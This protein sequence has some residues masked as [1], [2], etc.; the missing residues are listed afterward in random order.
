M[1]MLLWLT[2]TAASGTVRARPGRLSALSVS[3]RKSGLHGAFLWARR[4]RN[5]PKRRFSARAEEACR[6]SPSPVPGRDNLEVLG[7]NRGPFFRN[8]PGEVYMY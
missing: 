4:A 1:R 3:Q 6:R 8:G 2:R 7:Q 5:T